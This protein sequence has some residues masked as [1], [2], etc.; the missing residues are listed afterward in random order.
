MLRFTLSPRPLLASRGSVLLVARL[1]CRSPTGGRAFFPSLSILAGYICPA[2]CL[3]AAR[4]MPSYSE[5]PVGDDARPIGGAT[6][7]FE[8]EEDHKKASC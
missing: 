7:L 3:V 5:A 1:G 8:K 2:S 4:V 6:H